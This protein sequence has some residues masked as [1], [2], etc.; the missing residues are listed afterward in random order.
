MPRPTGSRAVSHMSAFERADVGAENEMKSSGGSTTGAEAAN[1]GPAAA[2]A[3][4]SV[5]ASR[6]ADV[7]SG[8]CIGAGAAVGASSMWSS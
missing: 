8:F 4:P 7:E 5:G 1:A 6:N 3:K 2:E